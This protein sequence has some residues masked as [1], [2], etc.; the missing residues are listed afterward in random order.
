MPKEVKLD[1]GRGNAILT[2]EVALGAR[3][4]LHR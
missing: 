3:L 4:D 1:V 2:A